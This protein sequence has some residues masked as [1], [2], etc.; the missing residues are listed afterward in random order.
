MEDENLTDGAAECK[1]QDV[2][3]DAGVFFDKRNGGGEFVSGAHAYVL[4]CEC[5]GDEWCEEEVDDCETAGDD[6]LS[7]HHLWAGIGLEFRKDVV[8][9]RIRQSV[10][11]EINT[12]QK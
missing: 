5:W 2:P 1:A 8:L 10:E 11:E 3:A 9:R 4:T 12:Q 6:V 7:T